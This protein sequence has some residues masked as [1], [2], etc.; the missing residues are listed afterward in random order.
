MSVPCRALSSLHRLSAAAVRGAFPALALGLLLALGACGAQRAAPPPTE[1][2][3]V[4]LGG[5]VPL[6]LEL[7]PTYELQTEVGPN[8]DVFHVWRVPPLPPDKDT[9]LGIYVG[10][11]ATAYCRPDEGSYQSAAF[12]AWNVR[13]HLC[14]EADTRGRVREAHVRG[15]TAVPLHVFIVGPDD[16]E[17]RRLRVIAET[18]VPR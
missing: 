8:F 1:P 2:R 15:A 10:F 16:A 6:R 3:T 9:S 18:L 17:A 4:E 5:R 12:R 11:P 14:G 13:W 7:P